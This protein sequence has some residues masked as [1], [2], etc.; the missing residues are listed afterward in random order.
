MEQLNLLDADD[1]TRAGEN[2]LDLLLGE[3]H[4]LPGEIEGLYE[5]M[6]ARAEKAHGARWARPF[7]CLLAVSRQGWRESDLESMLPAAARILF[8]EGDDAPLLWDPLKFAVLRRGFRAHILQRGALAQWD[9]AHAQM[10]AAIL[11]C[12]LPGIE[13]LRGLHLAIADH[14]ESLP[15]GDP[16]RCGETMFHLIG[17]GHGA[18]SAGYYAGEM[19]RSAEDRGD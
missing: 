7:A 3:A 18:R 2:L 13:M 4:R 19:N 10:R 1:F 17:S 16:M 15:A 5:V 12:A 8:P 9:F 11:R 14:L 6:L